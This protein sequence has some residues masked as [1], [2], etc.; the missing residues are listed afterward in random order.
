VRG[1]GYSVIPL[2]TISLIFPSMT[3]DKQ[4]LLYLYKLECTETV[5]TALLLT[6]PVNIHVD[7]F[8]SFAKS[9][10]ELIG[11]CHEKNAERNKISKPKCRKQHTVNSFDLKQLL[12][13]K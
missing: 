6:R 10:S 13:L 3:S 2:S 11:I 7:V 4:R 8:L 12:C 1:Q 9:R 5:K